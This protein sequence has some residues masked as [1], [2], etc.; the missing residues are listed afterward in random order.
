MIDFKYLVINRHAIIQ[1]GV[2][3]TAENAQKAHDQGVLI[4]GVNP[5]TLDT[6]I[7]TLY[8]YDVVDGESVIELLGPL[9]PVA[10]R[11]A[12]IITEKEAPRVLYKKDNHWVPGL[13]CGIKVGTPGY[14]RVTSDGCATYDIVH[15]NDVMLVD[16]A[17]VCAFE[18]YRPKKALPEDECKGK[19]MVPEEGE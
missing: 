15:A 3:V 18:Q 2:R 1:R 10:H 5:Y 17:G 7:G 6:T 11:I 13:L 19:A 14:Y 4:L 9:P 16:Q 8:A 12:Y